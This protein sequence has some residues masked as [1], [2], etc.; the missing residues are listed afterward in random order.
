MNIYGIIALRIRQQHEKKKNNQNK[1]VKQ[2]A[3][4]SSF[5]VL[6][7]DGWMDRKK[8]WKN[9]TA[10]QNKSKKKHSYVYAAYEVRVVVKWKKWKYFDF[11]VAIVKNSLL[12]I[13]N[14]Q[15]KKKKSSF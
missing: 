1:Q 13:R 4:L 15:T 7:I 6:S 9:K 12:L 10:K 8:K 11:L 3:I 5:F 14:I 2:N